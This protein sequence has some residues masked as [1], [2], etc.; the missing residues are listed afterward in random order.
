M[1]VQSNFKE[2][3]LKVRKPDKKNNNIYYLSNKTILYSFFKKHLLKLINCLIASSPEVFI[4]LKSTFTI[5]T[6]NPFVNIRSCL[7][8]V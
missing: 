7:R 3:K 1:S 2:N 4:D 6:L 5:K 8:W